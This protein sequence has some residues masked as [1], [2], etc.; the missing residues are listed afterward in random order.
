M[1]GSLVIVSEAGAEWPEDDGVPLMPEDREDWIRLH[2]LF[3]ETLDEIGPRYCVFP[4]FMT[5][6][7]ENVDFVLS[8]WGHWEGDRQ[9]G[10]TL[11]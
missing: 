6:L 11:A 7:S 8:L 10:K 2:W 5:D 1:A 4:A 3:C 9:N